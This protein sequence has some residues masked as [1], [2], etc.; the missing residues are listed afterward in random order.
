MSQLVSFPALGLPLD[1]PGLFLGDISLVCY[2]STWRQSGLEGALPAPL[3][4]HSKHQRVSCIGFLFGCFP[5]FL[6][7]Y[8]YSF[9]IAINF[10]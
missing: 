9:F 8:I 6:Y 4:K 10:I 7:I 2:D 5:S 3:S 1:S